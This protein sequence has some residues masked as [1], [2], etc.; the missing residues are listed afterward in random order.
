MALF[1]SNVWKAQLKQLRNCPAAICTSVSWHP[2]LAGVPIKSRRGVTIE[3]LTVAN[4]VC[5]SCY[6]FGGY[7]Y[8]APPPFVL[9]VYLF[10]ADLPHKK[11]ST[12][13]LDGLPVPPFFFSAVSTPPR[14]VR[15]ACFTGR[16]APR[17]WGLHIIPAVH[18]DPG[19]QG[20]DRRC[21]HMQTTH[22]TPHFTTSTH[23]WDTM[24][25][26]YPTSNS[27]VTFLHLLPLSLVDQWPGWVWMICAPK[28][29]QVKPVLRCSSKA[30]C[31]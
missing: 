16:L 15:G 14:T 23:Q 12:W 5:I 19:H 10:T 21:K 13:I 27:C 28:K 24:R 29:H 8:Y 25:H 6:L 7:I 26:F 1:I 4:D 18:P 17:S 22:Q 20:Q 2:A 30:I 11:I 3:L 31:S 9:E